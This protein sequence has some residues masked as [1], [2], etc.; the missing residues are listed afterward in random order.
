MLG[1][2]AS[3]PL[4]ASTSSMIFEGISSSAEFQSKVGFTCTFLRSFKCQDFD[5]T[6]PCFPPDQPSCH[7]ILNLKPFNTSVMTA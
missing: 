3:Q 2:T 5:D 4:P 1:V 7:I 6:S